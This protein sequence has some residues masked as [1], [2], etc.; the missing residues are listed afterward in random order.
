MLLTIFWS[1]NLFPVISLQTVVQHY[2]RGLPLVVLQQ[3][4][5]YARNAETLL[6]C[7]FGPWHFLEEV[8]YSQYLIDIA[9]C[10][11]R[12]HGGHVS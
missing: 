2:N 6:V 7:I 4:R 11:Q 3:R 8:V 9:C 1:L 10:V 12:L 5:S